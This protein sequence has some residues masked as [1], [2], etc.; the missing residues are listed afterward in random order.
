MTQDK[1]VKKRT[2]PA[3]SSSSS[4]TLVVIKTIQVKKPKLT[5]PHFSFAKEKV[6]QTFSFTDGYEMPKCCYKNPETSEQCKAYA[7]RNSKLFLCH[8]HRKY[9]SLTLPP[10]K[11]PPSPSPQKEMSGSSTITNKN[12][13]EFQDI[14]RLNNQESNLVKTSSIEEAQQKTHPQF[15]ETQ[16]IKEDVIVSIPSSRVIGYGTYGI[17]FHPPLLCYDDGKNSQNAQLLNKLYHKNTNYVM[18]IRDPEEDNEAEIS[19]AI[20]R[21]D[22]QCNYFYP[23]TGDIALVDLNDPQIVP[24]IAEHKNLD[25][26]KLKLRGFYCRY[27]GTTLD[28]RVNICLKCKSTIDKIGCE[29]TFRKPSLTE[30]W[31][32]FLY[33]MEGLQVL[34]SQHIYHFDIKAENIVIS[35]VDNQPRL[36]DFGM[37]FFN[38]MTTRFQIYRNHPIFITAMHIDSHISNVYQWH[39]PFYDYFQYWPP[40]T[41][42]FNILA[43]KEMQ[44]D[45]ERAIIESNEMFSPMTKQ[46]KIEFLPFYAKIWFRDNFYNHPTNQIE[47]VLKR[48]PLLYYYRQ[49]DTNPKHYR[50]SIV[51]PNLGK[52]DIF[53]LLLTFFDLGLPY[54]KAQNNQE[55]VIRD[56]FKELYVKN[57]NPNV[58]QCWDLLEN[59]TFIN[60]VTRKLEKLR[61]QGLSFIP[62]N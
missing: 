41:E 45:S 40:D 46:I 55:Q 62:I 31:R 10:S 3:S 11:S 7:K 52:V 44:Y 32:L 13:T 9:E 60:R 19:T 56:A 37:A 53:Q 28:S 21:I 33:L 58:N 2:R 61:V 16:K 42:S 15:Q 57:M 20:R 51:K 27:G 23:L 1:T 26:V 43:M 36:I 59:M 4:L 49:Y 6:D 34:H 18:K 29:H 25:S 35:L 14:I 8:A 24:I 47:D 5:L 48:D 39:R 30:T 12:S 17:V 38:Q 54:Q 50:K 22:P